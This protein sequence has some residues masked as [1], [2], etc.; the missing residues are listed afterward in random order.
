MDAR[1]RRRFAVVS[2]LLVVSLLAGCAGLGFETPDS[3]M[4]EGRE[5]FLAKRYDE[6][7]AK[8]EHVLEL[9]SSRWLAYVYI[10][11]CYIGK[12]SW[13]SA[14]ASARKAYQL[15]PSGEDVIPTFAEALFGGGVDALKNAR[16]TDAISNFVEYL[17]L[18]PTDA[19]GYLNVGK[20]Y[21]G[22]GNYGEALSAFVR[23]LTQGGGGSVRQD[24]VHGL[25][26]GGLQALTRG[27]ARNAVGFLQEYTR[28]DPQNLTGYLNLGKALWQ[29]GDRLQALNAFREAL[30]LQPGNSEALQFLQNLGR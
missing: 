30:R 4:A 2:C 25:L 14:I 6:A 1:R 24:L 28:H 7:I 8:F 19:A 9:D 26:D 23:G 27:D 11:R 22:A 29:S 16:F 3:V 10:A 20:A 15:A 21:L 5:L 17:R 18:K 12:F 13:F